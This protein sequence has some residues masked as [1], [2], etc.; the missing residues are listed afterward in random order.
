MKGGQMRGEYLPGSVLG[1]RVGGHLVGGLRHGIR[2]EDGDL[3]EADCG[4]GGGGM[5]RIGQGP[6]NAGE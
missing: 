2:L 3:G 4:G 1:Q 5:R 6:K